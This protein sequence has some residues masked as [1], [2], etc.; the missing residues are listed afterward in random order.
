MNEYTSNFGTHEDL[1]WWSNRSHIA[2]DVEDARL[3]RLG[4]SHPNERVFHRKGS[5]SEDFF[6]VYSYMFEQM[7]VRVSFT[8]FQASL[9]KELNIAS[10]QLHP[11]G[12]AAVQA[13][14]TL[15]AA[16]GISP[17]VRVFLHYFNLQLV[18]RR[19]WVFLSSVQDRTFFKPFVDSF[20]NFKTRYF[21]IMI[22]ESGKS[23]FFDVVGV[24]R[25]HLYWTEDPAKIKAF[26]VGRLNALERDVVHTIND[27][28]CHLS[29]RGFVDCLKYEEYDH[30]A[31]GMLTAGLC[32]LCVGLT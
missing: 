26:G 29:A 12:W 6:F 3:F 30:I 23:E 7:Y 4:A 25:F 22:K 13:F 2:R 18:P 20:K 24:P 28:P 21:K 15:C 10:S 17:M 27:L 16:V 31:F 9:L 32:F 14:T 5:S 19:G 11:N 1:L 8:E